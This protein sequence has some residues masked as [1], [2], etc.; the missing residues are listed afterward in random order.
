MTED[1]FYEAH[2]ARPMVRYFII[3]P[4]SGSTVQVF[5]NP[6]SARM[7]VADDPTLEVVKMVEETE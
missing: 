7:L 2:K 4:K 6:D 5:I 3:H 1:E